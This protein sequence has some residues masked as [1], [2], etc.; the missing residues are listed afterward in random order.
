MQLLTLLSIVIIVNISAVTVNV[1]LFYAFITYKM[2]GLK[3]K[4]MGG[5]EKL[6]IKANKKKEIEKLKGSLDNYMTKKLTTP[7]TVINESIES[8]LNSNSE[9]CCTSGKY[10]IL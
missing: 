2:S 8:S 7:E 1:I 10:L 4:Y 9:T 5:A 6:R 3:R